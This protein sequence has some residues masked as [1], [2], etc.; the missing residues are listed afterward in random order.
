MRNKKPVS[1]KRK[2]STKAKRLITACLS[3]SLLL[4]GCGRFNHKIKDVRYQP[5][6][7]TDYTIEEHI[8]RISKRTKKRFATQ[9]KKGELVSYSV[10]IL[11][12]FYDEDPEYFLIELEFDREWEGEYTHPFSATTKYT[13]KTRYVHTIGFIYNDKYY[14]CLDYY[15]DFRDGKSS[16]HYYGYTENKKYY[17]GGVQAVEKD[18]Q[19]VRLFCDLCI[20]NGGVGVSAE[21]HTHYKEN[22]PCCLNEVVPESNYKN[23]MERNIK[24]L[25][26]RNEY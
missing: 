11:Y 21:F 26:N 18:G 16:Y 23:L 19:I 1:V 25:P 15:G 8:E 7:K 3:F 2:N 14:L 5:E 17:G 13:Y 10:D 22:A 9:L 6:F 24:G 12:A 20:A 4:S